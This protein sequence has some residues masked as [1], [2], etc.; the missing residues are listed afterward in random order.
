MRITNNT[1]LLNIRQ[2]LAVNGRNMLA[3][4]ERVAT[5]KRINRLSDDPIDGG[6]ILNLKSLLGRSVQ[7]RDNLERAGA[8]ASVQEQAL[9]QAH[10]LIKRAKELLLTE[11][12][13]VGSTVA[14]RESARI[15]IATLA[16]QLAQVGNTRY[17]GNY[18]FSGFQTETPAFTDARVN[19]VAGAVAGDV[20]LTDA[21]VTDVT[22]LTY[23]NYE[24]R[25]TA[26]GQFDVVNTSDGSTVLA[27]Q[28]FVSG[29]AIHFDGVSL[30]LEAGP[31]G[32]AAGDTFNVTMTPPGVYQGDSEVQYI[33]VQQGTRVPLNVP[34]DRVFQGV[35]IAGGMDAFDILHARGP[36]A[37]D[38]RSRRHGPAAGRAGRRA[39][40]VRRRAGEDWC[41]H[42]SA[43]AGKW[44][45]TKKSRCGSTRCAAT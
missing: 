38:E 40:A 5:Q 24:L 11:T 36:R 33:E 17:D 20:A 2:Q 23:A 1:F 8:L 44:S 43:V 41:A 42:E 15:E 39:C 18:I 45:A 16:S 14:T 12:N 19:A 27:N 32:P 25:F 22:K 4:Q 6:R 35:G 30:T 29:Q 7:F 3:A 34:G 9:G 10:D 28:T 26:P 13:E 31:G 21:R 37:G